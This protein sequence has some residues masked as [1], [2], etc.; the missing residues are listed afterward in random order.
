MLPS[1]RWSCPLTPDRT[2][3]SSQMFSNG[4]VPMLILTYWILE[5]NIYSFSGK[6]RVDLYYHFKE[7][8]V[9]WVFKSRPSQLSSYSFTF[10]T[11]RLQFYL[12]QNLQFLWEI[13]T[14]VC[15]HLENY[16]TTF[17]FIKW[18]FI[19]LRVQVCFLS[20]LDFRMISIIDVSFRTSVLKLK[21][22]EL[23]SKTYKF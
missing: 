13:V 23:D 18:I 3:P 22:I 12:V 8:F 2:A 11:I 9:Y 17:F 19:N 20:T 14:V 6:F 16:V 5:Q 21:T 10:I 15:I 7:G 1:L 4:Y